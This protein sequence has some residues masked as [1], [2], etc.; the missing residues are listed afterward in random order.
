VL[1]EAA[2]ATLNDYMKDAQRL[3]REQ[4][5]DLLTPDNL[6]VYINR[7]RRD[8]VMR[9]QCVRVITPISG[10]IAT[11]SV[12]LSGSGYPG[13]ATVAI[14]TPDFPSGTGM[15]PNGD[16]ATALAIVQSGTV[17]GVDISYGGAGY[18]QPIGSIIASS[19]SGA[20]VTFQVAGI[21][22]LT[23]GKEVY[24]FSEIDLSATPGAGAV[25]MV[26]GI[27]VIYANYRYSLP[28]YS[29]STYQAYIRQ[30][31][32][33]YQYV[34]TFASQYGQGVNGSFYVFP[35]PSQTY[36]YELD[37]FCLPQELSTDGSFEII[38][39]PW[40]DAVPYLACAYGMMALQNYNVATFYKNWYDEF[41]Q[42]YS[43][44]A[45]PGR[46]INPYGRY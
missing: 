12:I 37:C 30:Y 29:F 5:Q 34:P 17:A 18:F 22:V 36:Q 11:A 46:A 14:S 24:P 1:R 7:A 31:P 13:G 20:S 19:G 2:V 23:Q 10:G 35:L 33:Q 16:Q 42:R 4:R 43:N 15:F 21:N 26:K 28:V 39:D 40:T 45:R 38:P 44:Y 41:A 8:I 9:S 25:Y 3:L 32:F 6:K 27:S